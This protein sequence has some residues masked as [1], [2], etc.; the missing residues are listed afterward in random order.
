ML[1]LHLSFSLCPLDQILLKTK[2]KTI[3][4]S[5]LS[6]LT[7]SIRLKKK[8]PVSKGY[9]SALCPI[10]R[11][12]YGP[13]HPLTSS[14]TVV[15]QSWA[16]HLLS[17][18]LGISTKSSLLP[19]HFMSWSKTQRTVYR[20]VIKLKY[21]FLL[22]F[23]KWFLPSIFSASYWISMSCML[24]F[25]LSYMCYFPSGGITGL[26]SETYQIHL[27][28][29][30]VWNKSWFYLEYCL[31][32]ILTVCDDPD[33]SSAT[34][35]KCFYVP[36]FPMPSQELHILYKKGASFILLVKHWPKALPGHC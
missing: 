31:V 11:V 24:Q 36:D 28:L 33:H 22:C 25:F 35:M 18:R 9:S 2:W 3:F 1:A 19:Y 13:K 30:N 16:N 10:L 32:L 23:H 7:F 26:S 17:Q 8:K 5:S 12:I 14:V 27:N 29:S 20:D 34:W 15:M 21:V 6:T 4:G